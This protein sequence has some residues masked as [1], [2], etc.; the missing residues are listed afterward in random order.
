MHSSFVGGMLILAASELFAPAHSFAP[1]WVA[2][3]PLRVLPLAFRGLP[4][5]SEPA[6]ID[7]DYFQPESEHTWA[8]AQVN[9]HLVFRALGS[10]CFR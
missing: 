5:N 3:P 9:R 4:R 2:Q 1:M 6:N 7:D 8:Q 10:V